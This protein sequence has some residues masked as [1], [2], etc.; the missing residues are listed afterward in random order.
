M[1][2]DEPGTP[3]DAAEATPTSTIWVRDRGSECYAC[4]ECPS[5]YQEA[6]PQPQKPGDAGESTFQVPRDVWRQYFTAR[7]AYEEAQHAVDLLA[8]AH[9]AARRA[10]RK[11]QKRDALIA[12]L[13]GE[14]WSV[15]PPG[16]SVEG[17]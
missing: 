13:E 9:D 5:D 12:E 8:R 17:A 1:P 11:A 2:N 10:L 15:T 14:G 16:E 4:G 6:W 7:V 3:R